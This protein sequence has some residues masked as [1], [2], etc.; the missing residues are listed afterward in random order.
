MT[1]PSLFLHSRSVI[2]TR[3]TTR[4]RLLVLLL[5]IFLFLDFLRVGQSIHACTCVYNSHRKVGI[6][7]RHDRP[8][9][10]LA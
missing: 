5:T 4:L 7:A 10:H 1:G 6:C 8:I 9:S 2:R 3:G